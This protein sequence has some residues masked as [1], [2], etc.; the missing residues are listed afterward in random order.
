[1]TPADIEQ[2]RE[3]C[4]QILRAFPGTTITVR[5]K[6]NPQSERAAA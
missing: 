3:F 2:V 4:R 5:E 1:M 6:T